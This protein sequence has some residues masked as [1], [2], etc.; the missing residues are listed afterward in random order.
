VQ[1]EPPAW[2][3]REMK[4]PWVV[5]EARELWRAGAGTAEA[6]AIGMLL[7]Y[8]GG[9]AGRLNGDFR[10]EWR[11]ADRGETCSG[12]GEMDAVFLG[13]REAGEESAGGADKGAGVYVDAA[14]KNPRRRFREMVNAG[15]VRILGGVG[16]ADRAKA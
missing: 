5:A 10:A 2:L 7:C 3:S 6:A 13:R 8:A 15:W 12:V 11:S 1:Q 14:K 9:F 4:D 16:A